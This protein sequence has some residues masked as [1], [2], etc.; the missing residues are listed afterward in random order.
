MTV[1]IK[2]SYER[3]EELKR[4]VEKLGKDVKN[5]KVPRQH[6]GKL[7]KAY[8]ELKDTCDVATDVIQ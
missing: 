7:C 1:K 8:I 6:K 4:I 3:S 2:I 5:V